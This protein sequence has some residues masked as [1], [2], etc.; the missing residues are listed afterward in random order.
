MQHYQQEQSKKLHQEYERQ[1]NFIK[2][3]ISLSL[4]TTGERERLKQL[5]KQRLM[6][7]GWKE[8]MKQYAKQIVREKGR[9][10]D[11]STENLLSDITPKAR[12]L[13]PDSTKEEIL[14]QVRN[15][16]EE[17]NFV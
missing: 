4:S 2:K 10:D 5:L 16:I 12:E 8:E 1:E 14:K 17:N 9:I 6:E 3:S 15:F 11:Y 13:V 7:S